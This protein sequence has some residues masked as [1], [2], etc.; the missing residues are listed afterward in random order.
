MKSFTRSRLWPL[1][2]LFLL[3]GGGLALAIEPPAQS[4]A[5]SVFDP[6]KPFLDQ[7]G[8]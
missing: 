1:T 2:L 4:A 8:V 7:C 3:A 6:S 5:V